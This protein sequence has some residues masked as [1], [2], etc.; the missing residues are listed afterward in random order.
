MRNINNYRLNNS[1]AEDVNEDE[2]TFIPSLGGHLTNM[3]LPGVLSKPLN[4]SVAAPS[5][6]ENKICGAFPALDE[7]SCAFSHQTHIT[8]VSFK[9]A[10]L[11]LDKE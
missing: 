9:I 2:T 3:S 1:S 11:K 4:A 10:D 6:R 7:L 8:A 5:M